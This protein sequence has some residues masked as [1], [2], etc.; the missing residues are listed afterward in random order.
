[1][2]FCLLLAAK[3]W[4]MEL[5]RI[6]PENLTKPDYW[7]GFETLFISGAGRSSQWPIV[8]RRFYGWVQKHGRLFH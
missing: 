3:F 5:L 4:L 2:I 1:M 6:A 7:I 8:G